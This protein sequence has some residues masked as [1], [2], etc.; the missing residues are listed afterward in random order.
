LFRRKSRKSSGRTD[1][2]IWIHVS[3]CP[4]DIKCHITVSPLLVHNHVTFSFVQITPTRLLI[5]FIIDIAIEIKSVLE[6]TVRIAED[7]S[8]IP[9]N[10]TNHLVF[11][12]FGVG[13]ISEAQSMSTGN[14]ES[15]LRTFYM[16][17]TCCA[18]VLW[19]HPACTYPII[20]INDG[21][22]VRVNSFCF[23]LIV[24]AQEAY[25]V[26]R[27]TRCSKEVSIFHWVQYDST[28]FIEMLFDLWFGK[29]ARVYLRSARSN[30][31]G[32]I[33]WVGYTLSHDCVVRVG[34][35]KCRVLVSLRTEI[36]A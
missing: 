3:S 23:F 35:V 6:T 27:I 20:Y 21:R 7:A 14:Y 17:D 18:R 22:Q 28:A 11:Q 5:G 16:L 34:Y 8:I 4:N 24:V 31:Y 33:L 26:V 25:P 2:R 9:S 15:R 13:K 29:L 12:W 30:V 32:G 10:A 1:K 19:N 36:K